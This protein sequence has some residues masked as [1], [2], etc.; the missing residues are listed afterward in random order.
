MGIQG[1]FF[2]L[3]NATLQPLLTTYVTALTQI[4][5]AGQSYAIGGRSYN[6]A[7]IAEVQSTIAEL[8]AAIDR[9]N[10]A[11]ITRTYAGMNSRN[12]PG[13]PNNGLP[14]ATAPGG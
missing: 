4:A 8:Q 13:Y 5:T 7:N 6:R 2:N 10:G 9:N 11:R 12:T 14:P 1:T 3:P